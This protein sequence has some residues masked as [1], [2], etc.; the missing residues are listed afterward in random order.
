MNK[1]NRVKVRRPKNTIEDKKKDRQDPNELMRYLSIIYD[2]RGKLFSI[3]K[4]PDIS[5]DDEEY[6]SNFEKQ[7]GVEDFEEYQLWIIAEYL[8]WRKEL[9]ES[10]LESLKKEIIANYNSWLNWIQHSVYFNLRLELIES[11][12]QATLYTLPKIIPEYQSPDQ[13][14]VLQYLESKYDPV[15]YSECGTVN[16]EE[17]REM[18]PVQYQ[19]F[20]K[21]WRDYHLKEADQHK[22]AAKLIGEHAPIA[23]GKQWPTKWMLG[24]KGIMSNLD[25][26]KPF[27]KIL[28][29]I[30]DHALH[31]TENKTKEFGYYQ[32]GKQEYR[33]IVT[34]VNSA[35]IGDKIGV[36]QDTVK[37]YIRAMK[38]ADFIR[39]LT[40]PY[41][42][43][44]YWNRTHWNRIFFLKDTL[45]NRKK[46][47]E[48]SLR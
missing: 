22:L 43:I 6:L 27:L 12:H 29:Y 13:I 30:T 11:L 42:A 14:R 21:C 5:N 3:S 17:F 37:L 28:Q 35:K 38:K 1:R 39:S 34:K 4:Y 24:N 7:Y 15:N 44:G 23:K 26:K 9:P 25:T 33:Y 36:S 32:L 10:V 19:K 18:E 48:L 40:F 16:F 2:F 8:D 31:R 41:Y 20:A 47:V 46:L 45:E